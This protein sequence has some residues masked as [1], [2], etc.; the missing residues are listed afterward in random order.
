M[1]E[2]VNLE[3]S[4]SLWELKK[5]L[6][7]VSIND[8]NKDVKKILTAMQM[9]CNEILKEGGRCEEHEEDMMSAIGAIQNEEFKLEIILL[10]SRRDRGK[11]F[12]VRKTSSV[13]I[14]KFQ[15]L[16]KRGEFE[17]DSKT[18]LAHLNFFTSTGKINPGYVKG[19]A[20]I[21]TNGE[22]RKQRTL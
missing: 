13:S 3:V 5:A 15:S 2:I 4:V 8:C 6:S 14:T 1:I 19:S 12:K 20:F 22:R 7:A 21:L 18:K 16:V 17:M 9:I 10:K 11:V